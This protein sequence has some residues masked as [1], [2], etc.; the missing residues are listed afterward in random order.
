MTKA[1]FIKCHGNRLSLRRLKIWVD[2][3]INILLSYKTF[4]ICLILLQIHFSHSKCVG[5]TARGLS[6]LSEIS[7]GL[8][9]LTIRSRVLDNCIFYYR[10]YYILYVTHIVRMPVRRCDTFRK[11]R[12]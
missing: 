9:L 1:S 5:R 4:K 2:I 8:T 10:D 12:E 3:G 7:H 11:T 6:I